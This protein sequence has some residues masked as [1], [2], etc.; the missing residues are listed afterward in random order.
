[1]A[2]SLGRYHGFPMRL[3]AGA[4][5]I[6]EPT[7]RVS[8]ILFGLIMALTI[9][10][11][12]RVADAGRDDVRAMFLAA[13]G[14]NLAWGI[15]DAVFYLLEVGAERGKNLG[16]LRA[17]R[18][19]PEPEAAHEVIRGA[20]PPV[21]ASVLEAAHVEDVRQRLVALPEPPARVRLT[22]RDWLGAFAI[23]LLV[24]LSTFPVVLPFLFISDPRTAHYVSNGVAITML[25]G[26]GYA[27]GRVSG[28]P[29]LRIGLA[30]VVI[31]VALVALTIALGGWG[32]ALSR[33]C[34]RA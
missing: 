34:P 14:C 24:F 32:A 1:M 16:A 30:M 3:T 8:E 25:F 12:L 4:R 15:I 10:G 22:S 17:V 9:T 11:T 27:L 13:L 29:P 28:R 26:A 6:L 19:A 18:D 21:I 2:I 7:E 31:G 23:F 5:S 33:L 20:L